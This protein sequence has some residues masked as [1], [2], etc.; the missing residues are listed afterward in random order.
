MYVFCMYVCLSDI[1]RRLNLVVSY[2]CLS[3]LFGR[4]RSRFT[5]WIFLI[6][7]Q[8]KHYPLRQV[9]AASTVQQRDT[10]E[11]VSLVCLSV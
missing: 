7:F 5:L 3:V 11:S 4:S 1:G 8:T 2:V 6:L 9:M 10:E